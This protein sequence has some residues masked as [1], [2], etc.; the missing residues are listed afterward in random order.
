MNE[1]TTPYSDAGARPAGDPPSSA[2]PPAYG[3]PP[4]GPS[5]WDGRFGADDPGPP[6]STRP[7]PND[8]RGSA[9]EPADPPRWGP[10]TDP[11][12]DGPVH[13]GPGH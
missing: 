2:A 13:Y 6:G 5:A 9:D 4:P 11:P 10:R 8:G 12:D 3:T 1:P 7:L